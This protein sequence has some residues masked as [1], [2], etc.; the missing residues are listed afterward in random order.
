MI[1]VLLF[2]FVCLVGSVSACIVE[3]PTNH[4]QALKEQGFLEIGNP[5]Y[6]RKDYQHLYHS[7]DRLIDLMSEDPAFFHAMRASEQE[8]LSSEELKLRYCGTPP[9]YRDPK[10]DI[11]KKH[12]KIYFQFIKEHYDLLKE[13]HPLEFEQCSEFFEE[14]MRIDQLAKNFFS[15]VLEN[16]AHD[17]PNIKEA[18]FGKHEDLT[19]VSK[20]VRYRKTDHWGTTPHFDKS[21]LSLIWDSSDANYD[22]L[23]LCIDLQQPSIDKLEKPARKFT[24]DQGL[25]SVILIPG[26]CLSKMGIDIL[27]TLHGVQPLKQ[28]YRYAVISFAL[29]PNIETKD[30]ATD[31]VD[32]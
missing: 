19:V 17:C 2:V 28:E 18:M 14:M 24:Y 30:I 27:P 21:G 8:F 4:Y 16:L 7:F 5:S 11:Q 3:P 25:N 20:I 32:R 13:G 15:A 6:L 22:S 23:V 29:I 1:N 9:S 31:F 12:N 26:S 10:K